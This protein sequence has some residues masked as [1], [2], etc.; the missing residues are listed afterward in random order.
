MIEK[1]KRG[2]GNVLGRR[3]G[4]DGEEIGEGVAGKDK[5]S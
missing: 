5:E 4:G 1:E 2:S 3:E